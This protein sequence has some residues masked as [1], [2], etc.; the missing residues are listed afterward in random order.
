[1]TDLLSLAARHGHLLIFLLV[2]AESVGLP[3]PASLAL[4]AGGAAA[5]AHAQHAPLVLVLAVSAMMI[6]DTLTFT[7]GRLAGWAL[8]GFLCRLS[9]NP[10]T[11]SS[12]PPNLSTGAASSLCCSPSSSPASTPW[13]RPWPAA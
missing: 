3:L 1:M 11:A 5:A 2:L 8:L 6:G 10:E 13:R 4:V 7:F 9:M 12:V